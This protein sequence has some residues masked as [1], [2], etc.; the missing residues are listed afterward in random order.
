MCKKD[1]RRNFVHFMFVLPALALFLIIYIIPFI[2]GIP[3]SL[4][5]WNGV[6]ANYRFVGLNNYKALIMNDDFRMVLGNTLYFT[7]IYLVLCNA[8]G[9]LFALKLSGNTRFNAFLRSVFFIPFVVALVTTAFIWRY[10]YS[11]VF[12]S[13][14]HL[15]SPLGIV[16]QAMLGIVFNAVWRDTGYCMIIYIAALQTVPVEYYEAADMDGAGRLR[17]FLSITVPSIMPAFTA[18]ITLILAWGLKLFDY[19]MAA[20]SGGPGRATMSVAMYVYNN[21][22]SYMKAGYGQ[23]GAILM[24]IMMV[25][26]STVIN[27]ALRSREVEA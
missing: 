5:N 8:L 21:Q 9:L 13:L 6:G 20:T 22:F 1:A 25:I 16:G 10:L 19:P 17:K 23:A 7:V 11:D 4:T 15:P 26:L 24:T 14:F 3:Y 27:Y 18:N 2:Q 12:S